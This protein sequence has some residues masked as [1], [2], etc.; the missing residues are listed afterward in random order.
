MLE[1]HD[2]TDCIATEVR[3]PVAALLDPAHAAQLRALLE[4]RGVL[5]FKELN[6]TDEQQVTLASNLGTLRAEGKD[7]IF[8]ITLD[9]DANAQ[10][11]YLKGSFNW[12]LDGTHDDVPIFASLLSGRR[13]SSEGGE[14]QFAN[15]Y[16]AY[17]E[18]P[19]EMKDRID[20][21][22]VVH[23]FAVSMRRAGVAPSAAT[24]A[25]WDSIGDKTHN[26]VWRHKSGRRSLVIGCHASHV[27]GMAPDESEA[28]LDELLAWTTQDRFVYRHKWSVGDLLI[29]NNTGVLHRVTP[30]SLDSGRMMH[31]TTLMGEEAFA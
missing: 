9:Q 23:S 12:H 3:A 14:T 13:L 24:Q 21:L 30:Y 8:K 11:D 15:S 16:R 25:H 5:V 20:G 7:G 18:L 10:A 1:T 27:V 28:L 26:L 6:L 2:L 29:W 31:R 22:K 19:Q 17:E 4:E